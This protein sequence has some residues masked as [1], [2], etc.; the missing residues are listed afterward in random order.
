MVHW[1]MSG[2]RGGRMIRPARCKGHKT[3]GAEGMEGGEPEKTPAWALDC[4]LETR[5]LSGRGPRRGVVRARATAA[6]VGGILSIMIVTGCVA[7]VGRRR[8][9]RSTVG[10]EA[11][12]PRRR[13][14]RRHRTRGAWR[15]LNGP[16]RTACAPTCATSRNNHAARTEPRTR[17][18]SSHVRGE[19]RSLGARAAAPTTSPRFCGLFVVF[20]FFVS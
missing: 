1:R 5:R 19:T 13:I 10:L 20:I 2:E 12:T 11:S 15:C 3:E 8:G 7:T 9:R 14:W 4:R 18:K 17:T 6:G 16:V